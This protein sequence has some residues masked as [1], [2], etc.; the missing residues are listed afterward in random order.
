MDL[1]G[2][3]AIVTGG[4]KGIGQGIANKLAEYGA[5][6]VVCSRSKAK[7]NKPFKVYGKVRG[8]LDYPKK[9]F[10]YSTSMINIL[11][12]FLIRGLNLFIITGIIE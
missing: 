12:Y 9:T 7:S 6:V 11:S 8:K 1:K 5:K 3:V 2:K 10:S 4:T